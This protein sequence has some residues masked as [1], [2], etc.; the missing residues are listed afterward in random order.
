MV[1]SRRPFNLVS[2]AR[3]EHSPQGVTF[4]CLALTD[5]DLYS[6]KYDPYGRRIYKSSS[7]GTSVYAYDGNNLVEETNS[8][9][10]AVARYSQGLN[11]DEPLAMLRSG[12]TSF[13]DLDGLGSVTSLSNSAGSLSQTY[14]YDS[15]GQQTSSTGSIINPFQYTA[16]EYDAETGL[17]FYRAR[18]LDPKIGRLLSEDP[19]GFSGGTDFYSYVLNNPTDYTD[20]S[21]LKTEVCCRRLRF[22]TG[23]LSGL[24]HCYVKITSD[25]GP[26]HTYGLHREGDNGVLFPGGAKPVKGDKTDK[27]GTC[28]DVPNATPCKERA[29]EQGFD[30]NPNCPSCGK[31]YFGLTTNSNFWVSNTLGLFDMTAPAFNAGDAS[32]G[33]QPR[34]PGTFGEK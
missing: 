27:G 22:I 5:E 9:G 15:F 18:Y 19:I 8:S 1:W 11:I 33:Y 20:P 3:Q 10:S 13:Y 32:P 17:Y 12:A 21:G 7:S 28:S 16:R 31:N 14:S 24:N 2:R 25:G 4:W 6:F 34:T 23:F 26:S 29:F 30:K